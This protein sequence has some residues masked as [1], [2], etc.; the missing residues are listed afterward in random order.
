VPL[1]PQAQRFEALEEQERVERGRGRPQITQTLDPGP[2]GKGDVP[3]VRLG[4]E[5]VRE[6]EAVVA[7]GG[8]GEDRELATTPVEVS[9]VDDDAADRRSV[10]PD[11]LG[12]R[13][14]DDVDP[15][16]DGADQVPAST[17]RVVGNQRNA[18]AMGDVGQGFEVGDVVLR[19]SDRL[20]IDRL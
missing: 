17:E 20:D 4:V 1:D 16:V 15:P 3:E 9:R 12:G 13:L 11:P 19:V 7:G 10:T 8:V 5:N 14:D 2:D 18:V 6:H